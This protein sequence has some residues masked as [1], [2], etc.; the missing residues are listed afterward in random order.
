MQLCMFICN[1][2]EVFLLKQTKANIT[3]ECH[4]QELCA[5]IL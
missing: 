1:I 5:I 3:V 2:S 4:T